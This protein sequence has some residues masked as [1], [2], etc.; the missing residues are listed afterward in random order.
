MTWGKR[1]YRDPKYAKW[2]RVVKQ[3]DRH[4]CQWSGCTCKKRLQ[5][6]HII[7]WATSPWLRRVVS[8]GITLCRTHHALIK[9]K[10]AYYMVAFAKVVERN[11]K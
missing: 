4:R 9:G 5:V 2:R 6:H 3:R 8:N 10:E 7:P 11:S 1:N